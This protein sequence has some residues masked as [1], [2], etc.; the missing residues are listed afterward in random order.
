MRNRH[1]GIVPTVSTERFLFLAGSVT[2]R[3]FSRNAENNVI[4]EM[5]DIA[6]ANTLWI[7]ISDG[8]H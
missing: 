4:R 8:R 5:V 2:F 6:D 7:D 1:L 3:L